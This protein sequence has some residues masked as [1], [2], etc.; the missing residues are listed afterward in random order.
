MGVT[1][2]SGL[3]VDLSGTMKVE[4]VGLQAW[5]PQKRKE[6]SPTSLPGRAPES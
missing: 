6:A 4:R 1:G 2:S 3:R 5:R